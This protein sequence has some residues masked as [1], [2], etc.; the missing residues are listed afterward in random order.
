MSP[1]T[2]T[3]PPPVA[4]LFDRITIDPDLVSATVDGRS[5]H[6]TSRYEL[7]KE[8]SAKVYDV[9]HAGRGEDEPA[10]PYHARDKGFERRLA[11]AVPHEW[12]RERLPLLG[13]GEDHAVVLREGVR[14]R[15]PLSALADAD[16]PVPGEEVPV[17]VRPYRALLSPGF[18]FVDGTRSSRGA[19]AILR[20][21]LHLRDIEGAET[22]WR[23]L[24]PH[25][26]GSGAFYRTKVLSTPALYPRRDALV[27]YLAEESAGH[28]RGIVDLLAGS[29][30]LGDET[31]AFAERLAPGLAT[32][33]EPAD[34]RKAFQGL[35]FGQHRAYL[36]VDS[37]IEA[38]EEGE[39][40]AKVARRKFAE[41]N[42]EFGNPARNAS[43]HL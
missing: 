42:V 23:R 6:A 16:T 40:L 20:V 41:A 31:P 21:Y 33:W 25:L 28:T 17:R 32:A 18:F 22:V 38:I 26:E 24:L 13:I 11:D 7:R 35:S 5:V 19:G 37:L 14:V 36:I 39:P 8:L 2:L 27:V 12:T 30:E 10:L 34:A 15:V 43:E 3:L 1:S 4:G 9:L 29:P